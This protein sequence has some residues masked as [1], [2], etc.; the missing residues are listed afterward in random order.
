M[1]W[2]EQTTKIYKPLYHLRVLQDS[3]SL[4]AIDAVTNLRLST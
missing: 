3:R 1:T 2:V 4:A